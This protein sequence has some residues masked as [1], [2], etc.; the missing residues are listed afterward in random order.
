[1]TSELLLSV[2]IPTV[3]VFISLLVS[4]SRLREMDARFD[5]MNARL[6]E[7]R[8]HFDTR[9][10]EIKMISCSELRR[11]AAHFEKRID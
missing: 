5:D 3:G 9:I 11:V 2:G 1:M 10:D 7:M 4:E 8:T 6:L